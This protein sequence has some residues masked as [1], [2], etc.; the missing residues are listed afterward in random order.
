M[1]S[2]KARLKI[3]G[4]ISALMFTMAFSD[5]SNGLLDIPISFMLKNKLNLNAEQV[6]QFRLIVSF[7]LFLSLLFGIARDSFGAALGGDRMIIFC[8]ALVSA[9]V[10]LVGGLHPF[11][12]PS[13]I[14]AI[15]ITTSCALFTAS[16]QNGLTA[17]LGQRHA[18][19]GQM[20]SVWNMFTAAPA[21]I[22]YIGGGFIS[23]LLA[24][25]DPDHAT[26]LLF[27]CGFLASI[28]LALVAGLGPECV[29][30]DVRREDA[31]GRSPRDA[32]ARYFRSKTVYLPL[33]IWFL[34][35]FSPATGTA[36]QFE[37][38]N[39]LLGQDWEWG[40]WNATYTV[41]FMPAYLLFA[42]LCE[43]V[44]LDRLLFW[45]TVFA[46][47]QYAPL[48]LAR[49]AEGAIWAAVPIGLF[50]GVATCAYVDLIMRSCP[51]GLQGTTLMVASGV[52]F[53]SVRGGD[54][55]GSW[56][57]AHLDGLA[58]VVAASSLSS[59]LILPLLHFIRAPKSDEGGS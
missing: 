20:S 22:A 13:F 45:G 16:A 3:L 40:A 2:G 50:G 24:A 44:S 36:L 11:T 33:A 19:C 14:T 48:L 21:A 5:P 43:R 57:Y 34:W 52:Y 1:L 29:Y 7:P 26:Q 15:V 25:L 31:A 38:Q 42:W 54:M 12:Y 35:N 6:S 56:V 27:I 41:S 9:V 30:E 49:S 17:T 37:L 55:L 53:A 8:S 18:M 58:P 28:A 4:Y 47:P 23:E 39:R 32:T 10:Y 46:I 51:Q 59:A